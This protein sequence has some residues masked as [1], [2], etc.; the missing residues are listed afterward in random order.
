MEHLRCASTTTVFRKS[1][2]GNRTLLAAVGV[3]VA[4][5]LL[6][7]YTPPGQ[8]V[9]GTVALPFSHLLGT[10]SV[11]AIPTLV[12]SAIKEMFQVKWL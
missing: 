12:L 1:P 5:S 3:S 10:F 9:L 7:I 8:F 4:L 11:A 2:L 6:A